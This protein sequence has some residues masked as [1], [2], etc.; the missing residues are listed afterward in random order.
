MLPKT[1]HF[2]FAVFALLCCSPPSSPPALPGQQYSSQTPVYAEHNA[3][4]GRE[5]REPP[6]I[7]G[8]FLDAVNRQ[9]GWSVRPSHLL[10]IFLLFILTPPPN[11]DFTT[12]TPNPVQHPWGRWCYALGCSTRPPSELLFNLSAI[13]SSLKQ[14]KKQSIKKSG[15]PL[16]RA[17]PPVG[18]A[19]DWGPRAT[20]N[21]P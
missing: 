12:C 9:D 14:W 3:Q 16:A 7:E 21:L 20:L 10:R 5:S 4:S 1:R 2:Q 11:Q 18:R 6:F 15:P 8:N 19:V 13:P 17:P